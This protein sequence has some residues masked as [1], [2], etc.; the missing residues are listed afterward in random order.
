MGLESQAPGPVASPYIFL[1]LGHSPVERGW[2][3]HYVKGVCF[4]YS[5][6]LPLIE[7]SQ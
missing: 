2:V 4:Q 5:P 6:D 1:A 3:I 7:N